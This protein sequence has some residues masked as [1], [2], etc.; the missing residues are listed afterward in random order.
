MMKKLFLFASLSLGSFV[1]AQVID[2][3]DIIVQAGG[4]LGIYRYQFTDVTNNVS[5]PRD[6][7]AA[8]VFPFQVEYGVNR[9]LGAG[10]AFTFN[11]FIEGDSTNDN[12]KATVIDFGL[13]AN[14]HIPWS[15]KHF[16][17]SSSLGYGYSKFK[18]EIDEVNHPVAKAGGTVLVIGI[19]PRL[20]F[21]KNAKFGITGWYHFTKHNY[22]KGTVTDDSNFEY[23]F[24]L[25]GP[26]NSFG[27]GLVYKI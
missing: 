11:N 23:K 12:E 1:G 8:W 3:N 2:R 4:G 16:D 14:L 26:G 7:S 9:W 19:N 27:F 15:L 21:G 10:L 13:A 5:N 25:D 6:T 20:Y 24:R 17:L 18:Y 22:K